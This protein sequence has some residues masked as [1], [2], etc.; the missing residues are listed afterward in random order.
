MKKT[1]LLLVMIAAMTGLLSAQND[2]D[3]REKLSFGFKV[4]GNLSNVYDEQGEEFRADAKLGFVGGAFLEIPIGSFIGVHPEFL[5]SQKGFRATGS[6][7]GFDYTFTRTTSFIDVPIYFAIKPVE[8]V[9]ILVGPQYSYLLKQNDV[10]DSSLLSYEQQQEFENDEIRRN[11]LGISAGFDV[12]IDHIVVGLRA[13]YDLQK[14]NGDGSSTTPRYKNAW[15][16]ATIGY[17]F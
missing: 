4:G 8:Y 5:F 12:N 9:T 3:Y 10:F 6:L 1:I 7:L 14:N 15:Y 11:I 16:Q 17:R 2:G 13:N